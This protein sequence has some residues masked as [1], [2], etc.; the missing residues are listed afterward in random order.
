MAAPSID[1]LLKDIPPAHLAQQCSDKYLA[2]VSKKI[3][4]WKLLA[5]YMDIRRS[6]VHSIEESYRSY[7]EQKQEMLFKWKQNCAKKATVCALLEGIYSSHNIDLVESARELLQQHLSQT[8][9]GTV[10]CN[11]SQTLIWLQ[12]RLKLRYKNYKPV[13]VHE[14]PPPL[15]LD[16]GY[17]KLVLLPKEQVKRGDIK[18]DDIYAR[19]CGSIDNEMDTSEEVDLQLLLAVDPSD[20]RK[21]VLFE[22]APGSGKSTLFWH[23]CQKWQS[24][25]LFQQF[26]IVL[27]VQ[28]KD[29]GVHAAEC[30][31]DLIPCMP[32]RSQQFQEL[33]KSIGS[34]IEAVQG[35]GILIMLDGWDEIP[36]KL[37]QEGSLFHDLIA[38][39]CNCSIDKA[40]VL[41]SSRPSASK[42]LWVYLSH[43]IEL[44][45][46]T[47][48]SQ[49]RYIRETLKNDPSGAQ[50]LVSE[51]QSNDNIT[52]FSLPLNMANLI[53]VFS[54]SQGELP[55]TPCRV[56]IAIVLS[57]ILRHIMKTHKSKITMLQSLNNPS[58]S[59]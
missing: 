42:Y 45:G 49:K 18:N 34:E 32:S 53:H 52:D 36:T 23:I 40:V 41:V 48:Q 47:K 13:N 11:T 44:Q 30:L 8:S 29:K 25:E 6:E 28:L 54:T 17:I 5:P 19:I 3:T 39:P 20:E 15:S 16:P 12:E 2:D 10:A 14:W 57:H 56:T 51:V 22:G 7:D 4:N 43:R 31:V 55:T 24:G 33:R 21:V 27:L 46:F 50:K 26:A 59:H 9:E 1:D 35:E 58:T 37:R 38:A